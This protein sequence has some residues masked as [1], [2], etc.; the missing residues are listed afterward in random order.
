M[1]VMNEVTHL[2]PLK[3][4][5]NSSI[6]TVLHKLPVYIIETGSSSVTSVLLTLYN[7]Q[8]RFVK[9][10]NYS[11]LSQGSRWKGRYLIKAIFEKKIPYLLYLAKTEIS[12]K[13]SNNTHSA[14]S[15]HGFGISCER[16]EQAFEI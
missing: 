6:R 13:L 16:N 1:L 14:L 15:P 2:K 10:F 8:N 4:L 9:W 7:L 3:C 12:S 11:C 5:C